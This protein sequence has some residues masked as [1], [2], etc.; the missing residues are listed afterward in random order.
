VFRSAWY[1][2]EDVLLSATGAELVAAEPPVS[3]RA[4]R[5][6]WKLRRLF[7]A[8]RQRRQTLIE[9]GAAPIRLSGRYDLLV[10][11]CALPGDALL[12]NALDLQRHCRVSVCWF[13]EL[14]AHSIPGHRAWLP[15]VR[16]FDHVFVGQ[17]QS[18]QPAS[19]AIGK[20]CHYLPAAV[21]VLRFA[22]ARNAAPRSIDVFSVGRRMEGVHA[23]LLDLA[24][25]DGLFYIHDTISNAANTSVL[26]YREHR[27]QMA[28]IAK[29]S[30]F[31]TVAPAYFTDPGKTGGQ[32]EIGP[33]FYEGAAAGAVLLGEPVECDAYRLFFDWPEAT[34]VVKRDGSDVGGVIARLT[35]DR[36]H[37]RTISG[38]NVA[39]AAMRHDWIYR[40]K[41]IL[42]M[43]GISPPAGVRRRESQLC[44]IAAAA[45]P[46][47]ASPRES[48]TAAHRAA[49]GGV[50]LS[51]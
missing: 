10:L 5:L 8:D 35:A 31:F 29:R 22:P 1:E 39:E 43:A 44:D 15:L 41:T 45:S 21:D 20:A 3:A 37:M 4:S 38:R 19:E 34:V 6:E 48:A 30:R 49:V 32:V 33:R 51:D 17:S 16:Q 36:E 14:W 12:V 24:V 47:V 27:Q 26:N 11:L 40:W 9:P 25:S 18:V 42:Q 2:A 23:S 50:S 28:N 46:A 7:T 13:A